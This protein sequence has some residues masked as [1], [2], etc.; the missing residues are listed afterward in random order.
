MD[1]QWTGTVI[2]VKKEAFIAI[3]KDPSGNQS[4]AELD[5][6]L[7]S[8]E[9]NRNLALGES[10]SFFIGK[11]AKMISENPARDKV[12]KFDPKKS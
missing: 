4:I 5:R 9:D 7:L 1:P 2:G 8:E 11:I 12:I 3:L 6:K 10:F